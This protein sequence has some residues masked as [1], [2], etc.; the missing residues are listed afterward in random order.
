[1]HQI[2][3]NPNTIYTRCM[4]KPVTIP[5]PLASV[6]FLPSSIPHQPPPPYLPNKCFP[7]PIP[8]PHN[9][10]QQPPQH[11]PRI[12]SKRKILPPQPPQSPLLLRLNINMHHTRPHAPATP[13]R[14]LRKPRRR[15]HQ[16]A[17]ADDEHHVDFFARDPAVDGGEGGLVEGFAEP[18]YAGAEEGCGAEG[19]VG[20]G[21]EGDGGEGGGGVE[22]GVC[23]R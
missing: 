12:P 10:R 16:R 22:E 14:L 1:M 6:T 21:G 18:D 17:G 11:L 19:A 7:L 15:P 4:L 2:P 3:S 9:R 20:E 13:P 23:T 8:P 5:T